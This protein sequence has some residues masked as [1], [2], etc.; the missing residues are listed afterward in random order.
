MPPLVEISGLHHSFPDGWEAL[1]GIDL[2]IDPDEYVALIGP[3]GSGKTTL[4]KHLNGLLKP[5]QGSVTVAGLDTRAVDVARLARHVGYVFQNPDHQIFNATVWEELAFAPRAQGVPEP[6]VRRRVA[7][8]LAAFN[9]GTVA[10]SPPAI[11]SAG[12]RRRIAVASVLTARPDL[13]VL[14]EPTVGLDAIGRAEVLQ[15]VAAYHAAGHTILLISH[16]MQEVARWSKRC[17]LLSDG[18]IVEDGSPAQVLYNT[19]ALRHAGMSPPPLVSLSQAMADVGMPQGC[20]SPEDFGRAY[21][22]L[23]ESRQ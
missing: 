17:L 13:L 18:V 11:L 20:L 23:L 22:N 16:D 4:A 15:R 1:N 21:L 9:L 10:E 8:E 19:E 2:R 5:T 6:E 3:N 7:E 14:D 12:L